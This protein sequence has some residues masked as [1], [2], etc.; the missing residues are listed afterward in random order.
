VTTLLTVLVGGLLIGFIYA[1]IGAGFSIAL[2]ACRVV[3]FA[4][5]QVAVAGAYIAYMAAGWGL[6]L[7]VGGLIAAIVAGA[8]GY[9]VHRW[10]IDP[11]A[12][13]DNAS[14]I[15]ITVAI[16]LVIESIV[17][18]HFGT[19][20]ISAR[21]VW[22]E[23]RVMHL[24]IAVNTARLAG[25]VGS[26]V[27]L[28]AL[29]R[30]LTHHPQGL[31]IRAAGDN[32]FGCELTGY[33]GRRVLSTGFAI[34]AAMGAAAGAL[35]LPALNFTPYEGLNLTLVAF[36][37]VVVGGAGN[38]GAAIG[39]GLLLGGVESV[40]TYE[41]SSDAAR[42]ATFSVMLLALALRTGGRRGVIASTVGS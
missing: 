6:P 14:Q 7:Y 8:G 10:L 23:G 18:L 42:I 26:A 13:D 17:A 4:H 20:P 3:N 34:A 25:A 24:G 28:I 33:S 31:A 11:I 15:V 22:P 5:G 29:R 32:V 40:M 41:L 36:I 1:A 2:G 30:L 19:E 9:A 12:G 37:V 16:A 27:M 39:A 21:G 35:L 38:L